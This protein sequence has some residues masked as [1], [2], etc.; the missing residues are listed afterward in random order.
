MNCNFNDWAKSE[1][2]FNCE[3]IAYAKEIDL[4][5][6]LKSKKKQNRRTIRFWIAAILR[7]MA[8]EIYPMVNST[9]SVIRN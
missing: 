2:V 9:G 1:R 6:V 5:G 7:R 4:F 8:D 3:G